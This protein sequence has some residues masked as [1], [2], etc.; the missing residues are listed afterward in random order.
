MR[1]T[2]AKFLLVAYTLVILA[3]T[4]LILGRALPTLNLVPFR[5]MAHDWRVG[6]APF[7]V[8]FLGNIVAFMP[9]GVLLPLVRKAETRAWEATLFVAG[10]STFIEAMQFAFAGRTAD[11]D[12]V[13]LNTLGGLLGYLCLRAGQWTVAG[14]RGGDA[15]QSSSKTA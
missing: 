2:I 12:D 13:I 10:L 8:N 6:G 1:R 14:Q 11:L 5:V 7:V 15:A 3:L 9:F 4:E